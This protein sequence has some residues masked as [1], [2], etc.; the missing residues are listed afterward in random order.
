MLNNMSKMTPGLPYDWLVWE[1][2]CVRWRH[3]FALLSPLSPYNFIF[4]RQP[5]NGVFICRQQNTP[6]LTAEAKPSQWFSSTATQKT[7][8]WEWPGGTLFM[9]LWCSD[10]SQRW[11]ALTPGSSGC[12]RLLT[13]STSWWL[14][15]DAAL[16][17]RGRRLLSPVLAGEWMKLIAVSCT[18]CW[19]TKCCP[20]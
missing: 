9:S 6:V 16:A 12:W 1:V 20:N 7:W 19:Y 13:V 10:V 3:H 17:R 15:Y 2:C 11:Y 18:M 8:I 14:N 4:V 5:E